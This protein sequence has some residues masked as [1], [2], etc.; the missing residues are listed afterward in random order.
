QSGPF[1]IFRL[2]S[3]DRGKTWG[4]R[5]QITNTAAGKTAAGNTG[6]GEF[7]PAIVRNGANVHLTWFAKSGVSYRRSRD[8]G[9]TWEAASALSREG[10][11][12]FITTGGDAVYVLFL[13][14]RDGHPAVFFK[15][16]PVGNKA[17]ATS[18]GA[19]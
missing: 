13:S 10:A 3:S 8:G 6:A 14:R 2:H 15:R 1:D 11:M 12:P 9:K 17:A 7:Y 19:R 4:P 18:H 5:E 16:D